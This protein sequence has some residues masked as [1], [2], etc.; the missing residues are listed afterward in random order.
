MCAGSGRVSSS[1]SEPDPTRSSSLRASDSSD[2]SDKVARGDASEGVSGC[3]A[4]LSDC[5]PSRGREI[6]MG[7]EPT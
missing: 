4:E 7:S 6:P 5:E 1:E 2:R 3:G